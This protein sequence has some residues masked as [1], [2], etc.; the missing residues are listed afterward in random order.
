M[1]IIYAIYVYISRTDRETCYI[2]FEKPMLQPAF[3]NNSCNVNSERL[4]N[5]GLCL[6]A[7]PCMTDEDVAYIVEQI[8]DCCMK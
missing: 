2:H 1:I 3:A 8:K 4:F 5:M 6:P 7:G